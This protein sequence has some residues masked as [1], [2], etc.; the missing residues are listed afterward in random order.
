[1]YADKCFSLSISDVSQ[2]CACWPSYRCAD[3]THAWYTQTHT[4]NVR[5]HRSS[6]YESTTVP[7]HQHTFYTQ[8]PQGG[9]IQGNW[10]V[11]VLSAAAV[12]TRSVTP[13]LHTLKS[14]SLSD[15]CTPAHTLS[16]THTHTHFG[17]VRKPVL[18]YFSWALSRLTSTVSEAVQDVSLVAQALKAA[19]VVDAGVVAGPL[20]G[21]LVNVWGRQERDKAAEGY[22]KYCNGKDWQH[23]VTSQCTRHHHHHWLGKLGFV[24]CFCS[25]T[26]S[27]FPFTSTQGFCLA[28]SIK[29]PLKK[30]KLLRGHI[31]VSI[32]GKKN[33]VV[34]Y[35]VWLKQ[36]WWWLQT[37]SIFVLLETKSQDSSASSEKL[38]RCS[39][40]LN[41]QYVTSAAERS[42][43][44]NNNESLISPKEFDDVMK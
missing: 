44:Q 14:I 28:A 30:R 8:K 18:V 43:N 7:P 6:C 26:H 39:A 38:Y 16:V 1:M 2:D 21:A 24:C 36:T 23:G 10:G 22:C 17:G 31:N 20:E 40:P 35:L 27:G 29:W 25:F 32:T 3:S 13:H 19:G 41:A 11:R 34:L 5:T 42:L 4:G 12:C 37:C 33:P 9:V 15:A